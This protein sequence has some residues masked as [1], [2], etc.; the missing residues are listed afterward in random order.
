M[1]GRALNLQQ[2]ERL[3]TPLEFNKGTISH[4]KKIERRLQA[5]TANEV[6]IS[7]VKILTLQ[8]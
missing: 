2:S 8:T 7:V 5:R 3:E 4:L 6:S 1:R